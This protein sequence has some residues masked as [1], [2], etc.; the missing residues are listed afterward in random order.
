MLN[1]LWKEVQEFPNYQ[2]SN[3]G[4]I[5]NKSGRVL[6]TFIQNQGYE[7]ATLSNKSI[8]SAKRTI[9]RLVASAFVENENN[10]PMVNHIDGIKLNN[11]SDNLEWCTNSHN[12]LH[13][14]ELG[15]NPYNNPTEGLKL[16]PRGNGPVTKFFGVSWDKARNKWKTR[17]QHKGKVLPQKR[18][19]C[20]E[21]AAR[22]Y[23]ELVM[24]FNLNRPLNFP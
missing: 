18:F 1:E 10:L 24:T 16:P 15:L 13:A 17:I 23:D 12:I 20:E 9:H 6:K 7:V 11:C 8:K 14:R 2:I 5:R 3:K 21:D 19:D 4:R 22:F